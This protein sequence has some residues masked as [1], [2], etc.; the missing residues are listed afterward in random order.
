MV[1]PK[2]LVEDLQN[3]LQVMH[4]TNARLISEN[5]DLKSQVSGMSSKLDESNNNMENYEKEKESLLESITASNQKIEA[6][7]KE[8][9]ALQQSLESVNEEIENLH[10]Q[11]SSIEAELA[12]SRNELEKNQ[13]SL[14]SDKETIDSLNDQLKNRN[15]ELTSAGET[16]ATINKKYEELHKELKEHENTNKLLVSEN[17]RWKNNCANMEAKIFELEHR[18]KL[19]ALNET[20][21]NDTIKFL[22]SANDNFKQLLEKYQYLLDHNMTLKKR[23]ISSKVPKK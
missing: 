6:L 22:S 15:E 13:L 8:K 17:D 21:L 2:K 19:H 9:A 7:N 4:D 11:L 5:K 16:I 10:I 20:N 3:Q 12:E 18:G 23:T 14:N 1:N